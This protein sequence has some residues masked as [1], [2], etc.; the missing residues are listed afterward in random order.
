MQVYSLINPKVFVSDGITFSR[1]EMCCLPVCNTYTRGYWTISIRQDRENADHPSETITLWTNDNATGWWSWTLSFHFDDWT[2]S[3]AGDHVWGLNSKVF[4]AF[5]RSNMADDQLVSLF[6]FNSFPYSCSRLL[7]CLALCHPV[8]PRRR[9]KVLKI[10]GSCSVPVL[11][12]K[13]SDYNN[14]H[15]AAGAW[16]HVVLWL[17]SSALDRY[18]HFAPRSSSNCYWSLGS[19]ALSSSS[20][21]LFTLYGY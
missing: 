19:L 20:P 18:L 3:S 1:H 12:P 13:R 17:S 4:P 11:G 16:N 6:L 8:F 2:L 14:G 5:S 15:A 10:K 7:L 21:L 9:Y